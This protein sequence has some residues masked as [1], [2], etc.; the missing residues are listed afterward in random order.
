MTPLRDHLCV[1][2]WVLLFSSHRCSARLS[3]DRRHGNISSGCHSATSLASNL[4]SS[5]YIFFLIILHFRIVILCSHQF[6]IYYFFPSYN[7]EHYICFLIIS[8][9]SFYPASSLLVPIL[10]FFFLRFQLYLTIFHIPFLLIC[11][12]SFLFHFGLLRNNN[13]FC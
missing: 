5:L 4:Q 10:H 6:K 12:F 7:Q 9:F 13:I 3:T 8:L 2:V 11:L 1:W